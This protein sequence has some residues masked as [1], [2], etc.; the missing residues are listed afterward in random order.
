MRRAV[1]ESPISGFLQRTGNAGRA[2]G[3]GI[4]AGGGGGGVPQRYAEGGE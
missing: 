3:A 2:G 1:L 4:T